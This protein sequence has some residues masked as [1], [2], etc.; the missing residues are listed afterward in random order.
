MTVQSSTGGLR[1]LSPTRHALRALG[2]TKILSFVVE[3]ALCALHRSLRLRKASTA[4]HFL[5]LRSPAKRL[6]SFADTCR[7]RLH[8]WLRSCLALSS[9]FTIFAG[10]MAYCAHLVSTKIRRI[11]RP[12]E[13][14]KYFSVACVLWPN[15]P[16]GARKSASAMKV[17]EAVAGCPRMSLLA[18][19][20]TSSMY[21]KIWWP[22][23]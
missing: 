3:G 8:V 10:N 11:S 19:Q 18:A 16:N 22:C 4:V 17:S 13:P 21:E 12:V 1:A 15:L 23:L 5:G 9:T 20:K 2:M 7:L 6:R 14:T